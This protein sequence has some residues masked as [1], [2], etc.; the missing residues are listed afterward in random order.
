[1]LVC[2][3]TTPAFINMARHLQ[4]VDVPDERKIHT[5]NIPRIGGL[6]MITGTLF[7]TVVWVGV[8]PQIASYL[9]GVVI[10][11]IFGLWDDRMQ[12]GYK[13]KFAGQV[14]AAAVVI[15]F[16]GLKINSLPFLYYGII[17]DWIAIPFTFFAILGITNAINLSDGLDGLAGGSA[18]FSLAILALLGV[19]A[20][21]PLFVS[22]CLIIIGSIIGFL[23]FNTY[24][25]V[26][27]MGDTGSQFLGFSLGV[28]VI[29]LTQQLYPVLSPSIAIIIL[30]L[31]ILDTLYVMGQRLLE[32][33]SPF[34]PDKRHIHHKLL[35]SGLTH[36]EAVT[37]IY[38]IQSALVISAYTGRYANDYLLLGSCLF[39]G[40]LFVSMLNQ[41][42]KKMVFAGNPNRESIITKLL[43]SKQQRSKLSRFNAILGGLLFP[44]CALVFIY[45]VE[46]IPTDVVV[47]A[48]ILLMLVVAN[49]VYK[50]NLESVF[51]L[52]LELYFTSTLL[53]Y[54]LYLNKPVFEQAWQFLNLAF[55]SF[56]AISLLGLVMPEKGRSTI[57]PLDYIIVFIVVVLPNIPVSTFGNLS[58]L[59]SY[60]ARLFILFYLSEFL[61]MSVRKNVLFLKLSMYLVLASVLLK[62]LI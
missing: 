25:A 56:F 20:E 23:R 58:D 32:G 1:M 57:T 6:A 26:V 28:L 59:A 8:Q 50:R 24:P 47:V 49:F 3:M 30:G 52:R 41:L 35:A 4:L 60:I 29:L 22:L 2:A 13:I 11:A 44:A 9:L 21:Q 46:N 39:F 7:S 15:V 10:I 5:G 18:L 16:G 53:I 37:V 48:A 54:L 40:L 43:E 42:A 17:P 33:K 27:F 62:S 51:Q 45:F 34:K 38:L 19:V 31:P 14:L 61:I 36:Y 12:L 55:I